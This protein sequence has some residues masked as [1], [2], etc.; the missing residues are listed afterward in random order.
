MVVY[1][2]VVI[3]MTHMSNYAQD[4]LAP[5]LF[6]SLF[7]FVSRWTKLELSGA[8]PIVMARKYFSLFPEDST[9]VWTV[10]IGKNGV[11]VV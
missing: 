3:Y 4:R 1:L 7:N 8:P 5:Y 6:T 2:Q 11:G 10:R 9:P